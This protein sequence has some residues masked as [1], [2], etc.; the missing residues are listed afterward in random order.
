MNR[1]TF[2]GVFSFFFIFLL[3][4]NVR[5]GQGEG[6]GIL[7]RELRFAAKWLYELCFWFSM[8]DE[9]VATRPPWLDSSLPRRTSLTLW[10]NINKKTRCSKLHLCFYSSVLL[11]CFVSITQACFLVRP[12]SFFSTSFLGTITWCPQPMHFR[13]KSA[14]TRMISHSLLPHGC[15]FFSFTISPT[16]YLSILYSSSTYAC[17]LI[18]CVLSS[19]YTSICSNTEPSPCCIRRSALASI[20]VVDLLIS[21]SLF[22]L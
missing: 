7:P 5:R 3:G 4:R 14:P 12:R 6:T 19:V 8:P 11:F 20:G 10:L 22:P 18:C 16:A 1:G 13:R 2:Q 21:T 9:T 15:G 17:H